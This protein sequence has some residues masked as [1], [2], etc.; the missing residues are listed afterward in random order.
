VYSHVHTPAIEFTGMRSDLTQVSFI[1]S[2]IVMSTITF[3][4]FNDL[5]WVSWVNGGGYN[6]FDDI[7]IIPEPTGICLLSLG[8]LGLLFK[9][10]IHS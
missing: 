9:K 2:P 5:L 7:T 3:S 8:A 4:D 10:R 6:N 1:Y